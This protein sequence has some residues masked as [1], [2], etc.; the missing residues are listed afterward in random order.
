SGRG[1][2]GGTCPRAV[3]R[4]AADRYP[5]DRPARDCARAS[6]PATDGQSVL[7]H[8]R[9]RRSGRDRASRSGPAEEG[10]VNS[11]LT[12]LNAQVHILGS[13]L[14]AVAANGSAP[15]RQVLIYT[16]ALVFACGIAFSRKNKPSTGK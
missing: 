14:S 11:F 8:A 16:A 3:T 15:A 10:L 12:W 1:G 9:N 7:D 5:D 4:P 6:A 2:Q 13:V